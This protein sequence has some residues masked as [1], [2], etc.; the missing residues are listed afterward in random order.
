VKIQLRIVGED[1]ASLHNRLTRQCWAVLAPLIPERTLWRDYRNLS[2]R[3]KAVLCRRIEARQYCGQAFHC[4]SF[5][6]SVDPGQTYRKAVP[7]SESE[8]TNRYLLTSGSSA[9]QMIGELAHE[10]LRVLTES[11]PGAKIK[12]TGLK[13]RRTLRDA[14]R[15]HLYRN[16]AC[17]ETPLCSIN[18][19]VNAWVR[20]VI[21]GADGQFAGPKQRGM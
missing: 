8:H 6:H 18:E 17:G 11:K 12:G 9:G 20:H 4:D 1:L 16:E 5:L 2:R 3:L 15:D 21:P 14:F 10:S 19:P 13:V 7:A